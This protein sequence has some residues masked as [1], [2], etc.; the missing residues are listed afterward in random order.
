[1]LCQ[2]AS[3]TGAVGDSIPETS[4][5]PVNRSGRRSVEADGGGK[6]NRRERGVGR[7]SAL[8]LCR[9]VLLLPL[10]F[11]QKRGGRSDEKTHDHLGCC[12]TRPGLD[13]PL[14][15]RAKPAARC[16]EPACASAERDADPPGGVPRIRPPLPARI[17]LGLRSGA[18]LVRSLLAPG[19]RPED[20]GFADPIGAG[21]LPAGKGERRWC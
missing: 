11:D 21:A 2:S 20:T 8:S 18:L 5:T 6:E 10:Q 14:G 15:Q 17:A 1:M 4:P 7:S 3:Q 16:G 9:S 13:G 19:A 12:S